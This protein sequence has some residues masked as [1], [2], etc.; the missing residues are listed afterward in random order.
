MVRRHSTVSSS[1]SEDTEEALRGFDFLCSS[2]DSATSDL[3]LSLGRSWDQSVIEELK[4]QYKRER[5]GKKGVKRPNRSK[6]QDMLSNLREAEDLS[7]GPPRSGVGRFS[8]DQGR[9]EHES[10]FAASQGKSFLLGPVDEAV[11]LD[12]GLGELAGITVSNECEASE[13]EV[14]VSSVDSVRRTWSQK[15]SLRSHLDSVRSVVFHPTEPLLLTSSEDHTLKLWNLHK[16]SPSKKCAALDVEPIY[17][18][19]AHSAAVLSSV[20][21]SSGDQFFSGGADG[22]IY[23]WN[24]PSAT[25]DPYDAYEPNVLRGAL[26]GHSDAVWGVAYS[27]AHQHLIS[28][29]ADGTVRVWDATET[30]PA[31]AVIRAPELGA[32]SS[33]ALLASDPALVVCSFTSGAIALINLETQQQVLRLETETRE[34]TREET[35]PGTREETGPGSREE[36]G[37]ETRPETRPETGINQVLSHPSLPLSIAAGEDRQIRFYDN[38][39][40]KQV[41]SMV[42]HLDS[43]TCLSVD[44][45]GLYL[46]S[47]S[48]DCSVR[49][50]SLDS[51]TCVQ[52]FTAHRRKFHESIHSVSFHHTL[53]YMS[54]GGSDGLAKVYV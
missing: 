20:M 41:H 37:H 7:P 19:R 24:T 39:T 34:E 10:V 46:L 43:V 5:R 40:G 16:A 1:S 13:Y 6:L 35:G 28:C 14:P 21:S 52:E 27:S 49:L 47:G 31:L 9:P 53:G 29:S 51:R 2:E 30:R 11:S 22:A 44:P 17:T 38:N 48:H 26:S 15:F 54:S 8:E 32:P 36:T 12:L 23:S 42:A 33:V 45:N 18:F 50:W 25:T 3:D 4:E